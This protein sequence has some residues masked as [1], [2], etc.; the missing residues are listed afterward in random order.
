MSSVGSPCSTSV[1]CEEV[2]DDGYQPSNDGKFHTVGGGY[3]EGNL[4]VGATPMAAGQTRVNI[5]RDGSFLFPPNSLKNPL[6][7]YTHK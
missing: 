2:F 1:I 5:S 3:V 4:G 6:G 7:P